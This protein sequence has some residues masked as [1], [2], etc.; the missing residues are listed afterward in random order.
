MNDDTDLV[1][2]D[3]NQWLAYAAAAEYYYAR[4]R[5]NKLTPLPK[6]SCEKPET[7]S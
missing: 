6:R 7:G 1:G 5:T 3:E 4:I 2:Y